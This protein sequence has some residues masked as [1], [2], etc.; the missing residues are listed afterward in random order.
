MMFIAFILIGSFRCCPTS[1]GKSITTLG[2]T[3]EPNEK[4]LNE[5]KY[6]LRIP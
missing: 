5:G 3:L 2:G 4:T 1:S 6:P